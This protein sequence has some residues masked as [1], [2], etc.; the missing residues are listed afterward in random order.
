MRFPAR[1]FPTIALALLAACA[2]AGGKAFKEAERYRLEGKLGEARAAYEEAVRAEPKNKKYEERLRT[3]Q[4]QSGLEVE[5]LRGEA[6]AKEKAGDWA[7]ASAAYGS[8]LALVPNDADLKARKALTALKA[9]G[10]DP[11]AWYTELEK[12]AKAMNGAELVQKSLAGARAGA[13]QYHLTMGQKLLE[14]GDGQGAIQHLDRAKEIEPSLPGFPQDQYNEAKAL[15]LVAQADLRLIAGDAV[16]AYDLLTK[17]NDLH[18]SAEIKKKMAEAKTRSSAILKKLE[19]ARAAA[20]RQRYTE[21]LRLYEELGSMKGVPLSAS[22]EAAK[23]RQEVARDNAENAERAAGKGDLRGAKAALLDALRYAELGQTVVD[24]LK[25]AIDQA[26]GDEAGKAQTTLDAAGAPAG[27]PSAKAVKAIVRAAAKSALNKAK[28]LAKKDAAGAL[29]LLS[30]LEP[31]AGEFAE[32]GQLKQ[33]LRKDAFQGMLDDALSRAKAGRD[34]EAGDLLLAALRASKAPAAMSKPA[35]EGSA[36]L[37]ESRYADA[38]KGFMAA[39][40]AAPKSI[41]AQRGLDIVRLRSKAGEKD[42]LDVIRSGKG[43]LAAAV[44]IL[45]QARIARPGNSSA[46]DAVK[47]LLGRLQDAGINFDDLKVAELL[48]YITRLSEIPENARHSLEEGNGKLAQGQHGEAEAAYAKAEIAAP[49][50]KAATF[51]KMSARGRMM[52]SLK[53]GAKNAA[54][55][56]EGS[57]KAVAKLLKADPKN[58]D[59][60]AA[61]RGILDK[62]EEAAKQGNHAEA[63]K[64]LRLAVVATEP[65]PGTKTALD[66]ANAAL[67]EGHLADAEKAY[68]DAG[69]LEADN[70][71]AKTGLGIAKSARVEGLKQAVAQAKE[72]GAGAEQAADALAKTLALDPNSAE[73]RQAFKELLDSA[74]AK[75]SEGKDREAAK[76]LDAANV[77]SKPEASKKA[78]AAANALLAEGKHA[79]AEGA[80]EKVLKSGDSRVATA[81]KEIAH[82]RRFGVLL[83][84]VAELKSGND[85]ERGVKATKEL[86]ALDPTNAEARAAIDAALDRADKAAEAGDEK[87]AAKELRAADNASGTTGGMPKAIADLERGKYDDAIDAFSRLSG[88]IASRGAEAAKKRKNATLR[89]GMAA[90]DDKAA[91]SIKAVLAQDPNNKDA[92][93]AFQKLV[94]KAKAAGKKGDDKEAAVALETAITAS[95]APEDLASTLKTGTTHLAEGRYAEAEAGFGA[96]L[97]VSK[98]SKVAQVGIDISRDRRRQAEKEAID[99]INKGGD[100]VKPAQV[101]KATLV[102]EPK[103]KSVSDAFAKLVSRAKSAA[104]KGNVADTARTLDAAALLEGLPG[105][106]IAKITEGNAALAA[107]KFEE[108]ESAYRA[109]VESAESE[110]PKGSQ[111]AEIGRGLARERRLVELKRDL[112]TAQKDKDLLRAATLV[113]AILVLDPNDK[114]AKALAPKLGG[115]LAE[116][117]YQAAVSQRGFGKLGVAYLYLTRALAIDA[118]HKK[119]KEE[120]AAVSKELGQNLDLIVRVD[121]VLRDKGLG[122]DACKD[123]ERTV[124]ETLMSTVSTRTDLGFYAL[125]ADWTAKV[126]RGDSDAPKLGGSLIVS[127]SGCQAAPATGKISLSWKLITPART[128]KVIAEG[129][130]DAEVA[131]G[132]VPRDEQDPQ[133]QHVKDILKKKGAAAVLAALESARPKVDQ[134]LLVQ[135]EQAVEAKDSTLAAEATAKLKVQAKKSLDTERLAEVEKYLDTVFR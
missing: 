103:S 27:D 96:A 114:A 8:A 6:K 15:D 132:V 41:L 52:A 7:G 3:L 58:A 84:S 46:A 62:A 72:G 69:D 78:I 54:S 37:S 101:L 49:D 99:A 93:A 57:A 123:I 43:D 4:E 64:F 89:A 70:P 100:P 124:R 102:I 23:V 18:S 68:D 113:R 13:Y 74:K 2:G 9:K 42:A 116:D 14:S 81:G 122:A 129:K 73:A 56:D 85:L 105:A 36:A 80:Y 11:E 45:E 71:V 51:A 30:D 38:E 134:W 40:A 94:D 28:T 20:E 82:D 33:A 44:T 97:E 50:L 47:T 112:D 104:Q 125:G 86:L 126:D 59:A 77:V 83:A 53:T 90:G 107:Q 91:E 121:E 61:L 108:A 10:L 133:G 26:L 88:P 117:R 34:K 120:L 109:A 25:L 79:E 22:Q 115:D 65:A 1:W 29:L 98:D 119:A 55:G 135:A 111:V 12:L 76:L 39:L 24:A 92:R 67:A 31:F 60:Q 21:A 128:G 106:M 66:K 16:E 95:G 131:A 127:L 87:A 32:I 118:G 17:A 130:A 63:A 75:G 48:G 35:E 19:A 110:R 5:R